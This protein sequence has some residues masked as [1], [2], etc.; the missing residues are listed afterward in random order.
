MSLPE[1]QLSLGQ[2][3][4]R[5][6]P[7]PL[8]SLQQVSHQFQGQAALDGINLQVY[9]GDRLALV[10]PSGAGKSTL[11]R[12]LN[13]SLSPS[14]GQVK[15]LGKDLAQI[16]N[17]QRRKLQRQIGTI[18]QQ[19][20]LINSL[21]VIHN[22]NAGHLGRWSL[23]KAILSLAI[24][25]E[26]AA[27]QAVLTQVGIPEKIFERTDQLSGG[28]QQRVAVARVLTQNPQ[29]ILADE[30]IASL[31]PEHSREVMELLTQLCASPN[32]GQ[33][34][35]LVVSLHDLDMA[36]DWCDRIIGLRNGQICFDC[37]TAELQSHQIESLY[38]IGQGNS[39]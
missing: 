7:E 6:H 38:H 35:A 4:N 18:Y 26:V 27:A 28:Q 34:R 16:S 5:L 10:G 2:I 11:L 37:P 17:R 8:L 25:Q 33:S 24:P 39:I 21:R 9:P 32:A 13:G 20:N 29:V 23:P 3:S 15:I 14:Q 31:D 30:P 36:R 22:V 19:F 12:L 1:P